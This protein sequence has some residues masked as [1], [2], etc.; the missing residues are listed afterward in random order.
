MQ[1]GQGATGSRVHSSLIYYYQFRARSGCRPDGAAESA[2]SSSCRNKGIS[3]STP[4]LA[5]SHTSAQKARKKQYMHSNE[6]ERAAP[7]VVT[8]QALLTT[9]TLSTPA[10]PPLPSR[11]DISTRTTRCVYFLKAEYP[12]QGSRPCT[13]RSSPVVP[14][15]C[16]GASKAGGLVEEAGVCWLSQ[17]G[18]PHQ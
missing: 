9:A 15:V 6:M 3:R 8:V 11:A 5:A 1:G 4:V 17:H 14:P 18:H 12:E 2:H 13:C 16:Q 10:W 7:C